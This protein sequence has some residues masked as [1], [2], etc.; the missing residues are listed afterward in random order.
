MERGPMTKAKDIRV[1][2]PCCGAKMVVDV[3]LQKVISHQA[4]QK[5]PP[6]ISLDKAA[7]LLREQ[8]DRREALFR[9]STEDQ[10]M[11]SQLLERKFQEALKKSKE[12]PITRPQRD[13]DLD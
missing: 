10:K 9:Q 3:S 4:P 13:F 5:A 12:E 6:S 2:C 7:E 11:K 8:A 1:E